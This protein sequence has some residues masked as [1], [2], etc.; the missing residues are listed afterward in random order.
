MYQ[1]EWICRELHIKY[2]QHTRKT[3][4]IS[5][6]THIIFYVGEH[7]E[8]ARIIFRRKTPKQLKPL[9]DLFKWSLNGRSSYSKFAGSEQC[10]GI[11]AR[12]IILNTTT[13]V[14]M[15]MNYRPVYVHLQFWLLCN[16]INE[17]EYKNLLKY[18]I[19]S[20]GW[21]FTN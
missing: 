6:Y 19:N 17:A 3:D 18:L 12:M 10:W 9:F 21:V 11:D 5:K 8:I 16:L 20:V 4:A 1:F 13:N 7:D 14:L 2:S 15:L